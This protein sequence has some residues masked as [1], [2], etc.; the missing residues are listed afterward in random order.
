MFFRATLL[1][2]A[3][4]ATAFAANA[5]IPLH[6]RTP[7]G[8]VPIS[9]NDIPPETAPCACPLDLNHDTGV[10]INIFPGYQCAYPG[11]ACTWSNTVRFFFHA[12][13]MF[14]S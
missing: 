12:E 8:Q 9:C 3:L 14:V 6:R 7:G 2:L 5:P 1:T 10:V 11:G 4:A 13:I